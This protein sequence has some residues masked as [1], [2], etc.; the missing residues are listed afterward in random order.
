MAPMAPSRAQ[1]RLD[2]NQHLPRD[3]QA[4][5]LCNHAWIL[6]QNTHQQIGAC[7][8]PR[9]NAHHAATASNCN[10]NF[11]SPQLQMTTYPHVTATAT[12]AASTSAITSNSKVQVLR[13]R[14]AYANANP[15]ACMMVT[16]CKHMQTRMAGCKRKCKHRCKGSGN[17]QMQ[18]NCKHRCNA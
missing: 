1:L 18:C 12:V 3:V 17:L 13:T 8:A 14:S 10:C 16:T 5:M 7:T 15:S 2:S 9:M 4:F 6:R 11:D